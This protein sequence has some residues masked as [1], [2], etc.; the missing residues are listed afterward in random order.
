MVLFI[1]YT[2]PKF[3]VLDDSEGSVRQ[4]I[5]R[6]FET[7]ILKVASFQYFASDSQFMSTGAV[8]IIFLMTDFRFSVNVGYGY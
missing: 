2:A 7:D 1:H 5:G 3:H 6:I 4:E 8:T